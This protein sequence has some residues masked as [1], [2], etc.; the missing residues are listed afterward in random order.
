MKEIEEKKENFFREI[1]QYKHI[2]VYG[3][4]AIAISTA[5]YLSACK[6]FFDKDY[7]IAV[8]WKV[9]NPDTI[10]NHPVY[11]IDEL[12][13][14]KDT[15]IV[16]IAVRKYQQSVISTL[17]EKGFYN[18]L[19]MDTEL[20]KDES[21]KYESVL[22]NYTGKMIKGLIHFNKCSG[23]QLAMHIGRIRQPFYF[24]VEIVGHCNLNCWSCCAFSPVVKEEFMEVSVFE[25]DM[26]R[27]SQLVPAENLERILLIGGEPLLHPKVEE[28]IKITRKYFPKTNLNIHTNAILL[29]NM[30]IDFF[31]L[32]RKEKVTIIYTQYPIK[33]DYKKIKKKLDSY[34]IDYNIFNGETE[35]KVLSKIL[36]NSM[37]DSD[38]EEN[39]VKCTCTSVELSHGRLYTCSQA[40]SFHR[41]NNAFGTNIELGLNDGVDIHQ[42]QSFEEMIEGLARPMEVCRFCEMWHDSYGC[43]KCQTSKREKGEW[44]ILEKEMRELKIIKSQ[45]IDEKQV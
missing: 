8:T 7:K 43:R 2:I 25:K 24:Q 40:P 42:C 17:A 39:F 45:M 30:P 36:I 20:L 32:C 3:A 13:N 6:E 34:G 41:L 4:R 33:L 11:C 14:Y 44:I 9:G 15:S 5:V 29:L 37:G 27:M 28:L 38:Y 21:L 26:H 35:T 16:I 31:E 23:R 10:L 12:I 1:N 18:Y 19:I 22:G